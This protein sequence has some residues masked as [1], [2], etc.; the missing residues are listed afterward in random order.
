MLRIKFN[1]SSGDLGRGERL[2]DILPERVSLSG[3]VGVTTL[4]LKREVKLVRWV[5]LPAAFADPRRCS[6]GVG[7]LLV[8]RN[9][10]Q[11]R[12]SAFSMHRS[13]AAASVPLYMLHMVW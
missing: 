5:R 3:P 10:F 13:S 7:F 11:S 8:N 9:A 4:D 2:D 12:T 1:S 6:A